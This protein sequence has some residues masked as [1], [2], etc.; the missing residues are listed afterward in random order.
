MEK[1]KKGDTFF[2][3]LAKNGTISIYLAKLNKQSEKKNGIFSDCLLIVYRNYFPFFSIYAK[4]SKEIFVYKLK[5]E[6]SSDDKLAISDLTDLE[7]VIAYAK[8]IYINTFNLE[9]YNDS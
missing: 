8:I 2:F 3:S 7:I 5:G 9:T 6:K 4:L 1:E